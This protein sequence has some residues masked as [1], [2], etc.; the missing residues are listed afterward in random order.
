MPS[1]FLGKYK[2]SLFIVQGNIKKPTY[3]NLSNT[4]Y[5]KILS[6]FSKLDSVKVT[7][8]IDSFNKEP[9][10]LKIDLLRIPNDKLLLVIGWDCSDTSYK[11]ELTEVKYASYTYRPNLEIPQNGSIRYEIQSSVGATNQ[12]TDIVQITLKLSRYSKG[13]VTYSKLLKFTLRPSESKADYITYNGFNIKKFNYNIPF[14]NYTKYIFYINPSVESISLNI[15]YGQ[16]STKETTPVTSFNR[17]YIPQI[18]YTTPNELI[19]IQPAYLTSKATTTIASFNSS[20]Y[21]S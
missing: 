10:T 9:Y 8:P 19:T 14:I 18:I 20:T 3:I 1:G 12:Q 2:G 21:Q 5:D 6:R 15:I 11:L 7:F 4:H 16:S 13:S 17:R